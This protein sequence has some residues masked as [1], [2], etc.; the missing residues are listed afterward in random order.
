[1]SNAVAANSDF[2]YVRIE[3]LPEKSWCRIER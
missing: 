3:N 2:K 1:V